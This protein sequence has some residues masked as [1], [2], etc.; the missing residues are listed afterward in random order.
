MLG[1]SQ[2]TLLFQGHLRQVRIEVLQPGLEQETVWSAGISVRALLSYVTLL[3]LQLL[4]AGFSDDRRINRNGS[5]S[6]IPNLTEY[7]INIT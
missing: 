7:L 1:G 5:G 3:L 2:V 6:L 4:S